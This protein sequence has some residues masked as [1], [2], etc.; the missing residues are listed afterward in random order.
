MENSSSK[1][2]NLVLYAGEKYQVKTTV[3]DI[4]GSDYYLKYSIDGDISDLFSLSDKGYIEVISKLDESEVYVIDVEL[5]QKDSNK[6]VASKYFVLSLREGEYVDFTLTNDDLE[7]DETN[8]TYILKMDSGSRYY[9]AYSVTSNTAYII[10]YTLK[11]SSYASFMSVNDEGVIFTTETTED[12]VGEIVIKIHSGNGL[13]DE[14]SLKVYLCKSEEAKN[15]LKVYNL[16]D[17]TEI[18]DSTNITI[19][20]NEEVAFDVKYNN[21]YVT[22]VIT[23][24]DTNVL[25][26]EN[27]TNTIKALKEG[28]CEVVF[29]YEEEQITI[30]VKVIK[31]KAIAIEALNQGSDFIMVNGSLHY[32]G[33]LYIKYESGRSEEIKDHSL[34]KV[35]INDKDEHY[36]AVSFTYHEITITYDVKYYHAKEYDGGNGIISIKTTPSFNPD[37][38]LCSE[39]GDMCS[40]NCSENSYYVCLHGGKK[41]SR[42][43]TFIATPNDGYQVKK[44]TFNGEK[45]LDN[46]TNFYTATVSNKDNYNGVISVVFEKA[47]HN[48]DYVDGLCDC[49]EFDNNW[50]NENFDLLEDKILFNGT[51]DD[52]F[53]C[54]IILLTLKHTTTYVELTKRHF[55]IN[56]ITKVEYVGGPKPPEYFFKDEYKHLLAKYNQIVFLHVDVQSKSEIIELIKELEKLE[57]VRSA[58]PNHIESPDV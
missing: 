42:E 8:S 56:C 49:G 21:Q 10:T 40:L 2:Y 53:N 47:S 16:N 11:D 31:D 20:E 50:L 44:W 51:V 39:A 41:D 15:E 57:F 54:D 29:Q 55:K 4:I 30:T 23:F 43:L 46:E 35:V 17:S 27:T 38:R 9:L 12:K 52:E 25:E 48:H 28:I 3:D 24:S 34:L 58:N 33:N 18:T 26:V 19:Y 14:I 6:K 7:Y 36:K 22:N 13:L 37:V 45:V 32:L 1:Y 5:Y